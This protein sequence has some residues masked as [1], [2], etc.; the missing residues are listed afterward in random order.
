MAKRFSGALDYGGGFDDVASLHGAE[1]LAGGSAYMWGDASAAKAKGRGGDDVDD[2]AAAYAAAGFGPGDEDASVWSELT[3]N[4]DVVPGR[5]GSKSRNAG[6]ITHE[7]PEGDEEDDDGD[8]YGG[9][10][11]DGTGIDGEDGDAD[12][13]E[14]DDDEK[15]GVPDT[16][17]EHAC[18]YCNIYN[19]GTVVRCSTT[20][21][22]FCNARSS[23]S[24]GSHIVQHL[25]RGK[26]KE[27][28]LHP[29]SPL[30]DAIL[31]CYNCGCRNV[32]LLGFIP[33]KS[34]SVV[35][36]LCREPCLN[37]GA[38]K[39]QGWDLSLW[40]P[41]VEDRTFLPWLVKQPSQREIDRARPISS[42]Q[43][44]A[45]ETLWRSKPD[46]TLEDLGKTDSEGEWPCA[47]GAHSS[48]YLLSWPSHWYAAARAHPPRLPAL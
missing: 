46:A 8:V 23:G 3:D 17:P 44:A 6:A 4:V 41:I 34:D 39:D 47:P 26:H 29:D 45:L 12:G 24:S 30:G 42:D 7:L 2:L 28:S 22:W 16:L 31:E 21:K 19:P 25:V 10:R 11:G 36:L 15:E 32:F 48:I 9:A 38:L 13:D 43:I 14:D 5:S 37:L 40:Q 27:V 20:G 33:S 1:S 35:V 18:S